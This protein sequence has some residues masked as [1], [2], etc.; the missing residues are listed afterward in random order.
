MSEVHVYPV[1]AEVAKN[2]WVDRAKYDAMYRQSVEDPDT[3]WT[4]QANEF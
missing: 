3:F 4:E 2:A 1:P